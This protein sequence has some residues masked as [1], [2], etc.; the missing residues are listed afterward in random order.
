[1]GCKEGVKQTAEAILNGIRLCDET[2]ELCKEAKICPMCAG[3]QKIREFRISNIQKFF[4][5][6][7]TYCDKCDLLLTEERYIPHA[8]CWWPMYTIKGE[9]LYRN[10]VRKYSDKLD[11]LIKILEKGEK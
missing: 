11:S 3:D 10:N 2:I 5:I 4:P 6:R 9:Q 1:M 8:Y 7:L